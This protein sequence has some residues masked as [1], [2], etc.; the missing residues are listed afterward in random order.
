MGL[1]GGL[2][3]NNLDEDE[4]VMKHSH[5]CVKCFGRVLMFTNDA[6]CI[7]REMFG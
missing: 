4:R 6:E 7:K 5:F 1:E 3:G 2:I